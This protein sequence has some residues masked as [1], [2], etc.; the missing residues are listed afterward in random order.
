MKT[1]N[2]WM[3]LLLC[4]IWVSGVMGSSAHA[5]WSVDF[6]EEEE[7][8]LEDDF[9]SGIEEN[10]LLDPSASSGLSVTD[11]REDDGS[12][13]ITITATG[14]F[15]IGG[16]SRKKKN[17]FED[18]LKRQDGDLN[19]TMRNMREILMA[20]DL[21][22]VNFEGTLTN[23][24]YIPSDK[25]NN[26]FLFSAPPE[27]VTM[28]SDNGVEAAAL[29]N[30]HIMDHGDDAYEDTKN[31]LRGAGIVYSN[32]TEVGVIEIKG[33]RIAML[34]YLCIDRYDRLWDKVPRDIELAKQQYPIVICSFHWGNEKDYSPTQNQIKMGR[35]AVDSGA[36]LVLG[37]HSHRLNPIEDYNGVYICYSLGNFCFS[38]NNKPDDM[39]SFVFQTRFRVRDEEDGSQ[40]V[41]REGFRIIP[42][43]I[44]SRTD[45][46]DFIPTPLT[47][48]T[49]IDSV[50][51]TLKANGRKL[52]YAVSAY[53]LDW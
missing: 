36:D 35:L 16:D 52:T 48:D 46:N 12:V 34:T 45:R 22:I 41:S 5:E 6:E 3:S 39:T 49:A 14:D 28:L 13:L 50:L 20:D 51:T 18:E 27:Y 2:R 26:Q 21:T 31:A 53:P 40:T 19:F 23:S 17:I 32:S 44:S 1:L 8:E 15:T 37:H 42:I 29:E 9:S 25:R 43:R 4:V 7:L 11:Y 47:K 30:N 24:D 38:G 10:G 33:V